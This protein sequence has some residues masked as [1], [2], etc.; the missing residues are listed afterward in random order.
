M[1]KNTSKRDGTRQVY[2]QL[3]FTKNTLSWWE[4]NGVEVVGI[5]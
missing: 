5:A 3:M 1:E 4:K 2:T